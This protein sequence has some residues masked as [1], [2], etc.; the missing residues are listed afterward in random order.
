MNASAFFTDEEKNRLK[1]AVRQ[2]E[3][4]TSGEIRVHVET[5]FTGTV[6][7]R[8]S[9]VFADL[10]IQKTELRNG[11]LFYLAVKN[12]EFAILG[13]SGINKVVPKDFW[14]NIKN[15]MQFFFRQSDFT[16]GLCRGLEMAGE[17]LSIH[18]PYSAADK[19]ELSDEISFGNQDLKPD[20]NKTGS[21]S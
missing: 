14:N 15:E 18:F 17:A 1:E 10:K 9:T 12:Q 8:A 16:G 19:N 4:N 21:K 3:K 20:D 6:L 13:D 7:D 2:A 5:Y 11:V